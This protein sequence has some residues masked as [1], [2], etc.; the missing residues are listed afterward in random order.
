RMKQPNGSMQSR[1]LKMCVKGFI[2]RKSER[3]YLNIRR[4]F[5]GGLETPR[6]LYKKKC[7]LLMTGAEEA[8]HCVLK[9]RLLSFGLPSKIKCMG[10][11]T[12]RS[13]CIILHKCSV[14]SG[15][16]KDGCAS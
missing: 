12:S 13:N 14:M 3:R 7:I 11:R 16:K 1:K 10:I 8:S 9:G 5:N 15:R 2:I 6:I 4:F